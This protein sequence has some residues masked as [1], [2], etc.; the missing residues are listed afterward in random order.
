MISALVY[1]TGYM[2]VQ[3]IKT[4]LFLYPTLQ[5]FT[6]TVFMYV[7]ILC[8]ANQDNSLCLVQF[9]VESSISALY[10]CIVFHCVH[11]WRKWRWLSVWL[12]FL[13]NKSFIPFSV[14]VSC[15]I[16]FPVLYSGAWLYSLFFPVCLPGAMI[17]MVDDCQPQNMAWTHS[18]SS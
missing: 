15:L 13:G 2:Y 14:P 18:Q 12:S 6:S 10:A 7:Y 17:C 4:G 8:A 11:V 9:L 16:Q 5:H 1:F 3:Q